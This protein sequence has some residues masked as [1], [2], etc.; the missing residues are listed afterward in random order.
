VKQLLILVGV[1][2]ALT[3]CAE[4]GVF[5]P[6]T[7]KVRSGEQNIS[8][9]SQEGERLN[10]A[11]THLPHVDNYG[12]LRG[13]NGASVYQTSSDKYKG[14]LLTKH[15]GHYVQGLTQDLMENVEYISDK[16]PVG[17]TSFALL[18]GDLQETNLFGLQMAESFIHELHKFRIPVIDYKATDYIRV[19]DS[20]DFFLSRDFLELKERAPLDF[21]LTGTMTKHQGGYLVNARIVGM[22]S[23]EVVSSAQTII[24]FYVVE[25]LID[26][27][28]SRFE[29]VKLIQGE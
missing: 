14:P 24:P 18:N 16:T 17:I 15:I 4:L 23:K 11:Q 25:A 29:G 5:L 19:T 20:G 22:T 3:G 21:I 26:Q 6:N 28:H 2:F 8:N 9:P 1:I 12:A 27:S 7:V 10:H 13:R